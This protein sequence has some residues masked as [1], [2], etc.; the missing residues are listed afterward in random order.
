MIVAGFGFRQAATL[1]SLLDA[2]HRAGA[3]HHPALLATAADK[4]ASPAFRAGP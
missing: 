2:L 1:D 3:P 4:A